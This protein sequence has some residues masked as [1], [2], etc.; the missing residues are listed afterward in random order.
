MIYQNNK[1]Q[2]F[3][4]KTFSILNYIFKKLHISLSEKYFLFNLR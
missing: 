4:L 2:G 1:Y 3:L